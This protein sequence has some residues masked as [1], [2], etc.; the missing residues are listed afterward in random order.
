MLEEY[1]PAGCWQNVSSE[2]PHDLQYQQEL[3]AV[4]VC[5]SISL[6]GKKTSCE[7]FSIEV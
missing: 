7:Q 4:I 3:V 1:P 6:L 5:G 2:D